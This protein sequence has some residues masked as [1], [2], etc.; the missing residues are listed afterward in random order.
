MMDF[1][2]VPLIVGICVTG[3]YGLFELFARR[4]ERLA[5]IEKIGD[6]LDASAFEGKLN[7]GS[8]IPKLSFSA[9]KVGCLMTGIGLG[10]LIGF[11]INTC[12]MHQISNNDWYR[13]DIA[14]TAYGASV[15][16]FGGIGLIAAF[17]MELRLTKNR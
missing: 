2:L 6:K 3:V 11:I 9:L 8:Y 13:N 7:F 1:L 5:I 14:G 4:K 10:L 12:L 16:L 17:I 15:L